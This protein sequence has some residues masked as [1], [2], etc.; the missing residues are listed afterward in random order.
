MIISRSKSFFAVNAS[1]LSQ[2]FLAFGSAGFETFPQ[3]SSLAS[4]WLEDCV[5]IV[6]P[7]ENDKYC[8]LYSANHS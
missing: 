3:V 5:Q 8:T 4:H 1:L 2:S 6:R 7:D